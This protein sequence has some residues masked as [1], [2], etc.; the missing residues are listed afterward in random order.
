L[1]QPVAAKGV[2]RTAG[3][4][5]D[6]LLQTVSAERPG[7]RMMVPAAYARPRLDHGPGGN[8]D[9][10]RHG[11]RAG[12]GY[13]GGG[14]YVLDVNLPDRATVALIGDWGTGTQTAAGLLAQVARI[15]RAL[16]LLSPAVIRSLREGLGKSP[17]EFA[18]L[19][20]IR[21]EDLRGWERA[22]TLPSRALDRYLR[23][24][25]A[26]PENVKLLEELPAVLPA[27]VPSPANRMPQKPESTAVP[28][29]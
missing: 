14:D 6:A 12:P 3:S 15:G 4:P 27:P 5:L 22:R 28:S 13:R 18:R 7:I 19:T 8:P 23:L 2:K 29:E 9:D 16:G 17:Q 25:A 26:S 21:E 11:E 24:L 10:R 1:D 20:G